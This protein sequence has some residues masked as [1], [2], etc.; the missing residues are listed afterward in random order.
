[1]RFCP[2]CG[3][4]IE[5]SLSRC[6][7]CL[8]PTSSPEA[9]GPA[10]TRSSR[11]AIRPLQDSARPGARRHGGEWQAARRSETLNGTGSDIKLAGF[12]DLSSKHSPIVPAPVVT[13]LGV[14]VPSSPRGGSSSASIAQHGTVDVG[15]M[16]PTGAVAPLSRPR[17]EQVS[18]AAPNATMLG[19]PRYWG[20]ETSAPASPGV[21]TAGAVQVEI[22]FP[23]AGL[24]SEPAHE[25]R[26]V[27]T[28]SKANARG[29]TDLPGIARSP[30]ELLVRG[31]A[32]SV[33]PREKKAAD[34]GLL[35]YRLDADVLG[36]SS[37]SHPA[38]GP[39][40][41]ATR[42]HARPATSQKQNRWWVWGV[43]I[44]IAVAAATSVSRCLHTTGSQ[45]KA[46]WDAR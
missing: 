14:P 6:A 2:K 31:D 11:G 22:P 26:V 42:N 10:S 24:R 35:F 7:R 21:A 17:G 39:A 23:R 8:R 19:M 37:S 36:P 4:P 3:Q 5:P 12:D 1:M 29:E 13:V 9:L 18:E 16:V 27:S 40:S 33:L 32:P 38:A 46:A 20:D 44:L 15:I 25:S 34:V 30:L 41:S 43:A 28:E 45:Q